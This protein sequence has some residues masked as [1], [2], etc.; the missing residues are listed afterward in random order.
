MGLTQFL[1]HDDVTTVDSTDNEIHCPTTFRSISL[2]V[3]FFSVRRKRV[4][5]M[6]TKHQR[7]KWQVPVIN[8]CTPMPCLNCDFRNF[9]LNLAPLKRFT[10]RSAK[11]LRQ[12]LLSSELTCIFYIRS[13]RALIN[14]I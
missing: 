7:R 14:L 8:D 11:T 13:I 4:L 9:C 12:I 1:N 5:H 6:A 2:T 10:F 3:S